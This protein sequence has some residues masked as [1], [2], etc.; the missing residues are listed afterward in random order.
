MNS[1]LF[2]GAQSDDS[3]ESEFVT[4]SDDD[5]DE[6]DELL[7]ESQEQDDQET[8]SSTSEWGVCIYKA[9][10]ACLYWEGGKWLSI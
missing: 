7:D 4:N 8:D 6:S 3:D 9:A 10:H 1:S 2:Y 5:T